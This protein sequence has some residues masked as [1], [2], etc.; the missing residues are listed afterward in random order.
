MP[1]EST[2]VTDQT[3]ISCSRPES[4]ANENLLARAFPPIKSTLRATMIDTLFR[5]R[6]RAQRSAIRQCSG[7]AS[8]CYVA[9][10]E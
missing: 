9:P 3:L 7:S 8:T 4:V 6:E 5:S 10:A 2:G 1:E